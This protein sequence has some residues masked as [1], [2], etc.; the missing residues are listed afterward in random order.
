VAVLKSDH[1][2]QPPKLA[3]AKKETKLTMS[4]KLY[5]GNLSYDTTEIDLQ[6]T[7][8]EAGTVTEV[9]LMQDKF[10]GK[11][12]GFAFVTMS[13]PEEAQKAISLFHG[14]S[15]G[16]RALTVNEARPREDRPPG[17][18]GGGGQ[19]RSY[20]GGG[21]GGGGRGDRGDRGGGYSKRY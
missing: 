10:T 1:R 3:L 13:S 5:V 12:R 2:K 15:V 20:G 19:R 6:D 14:K 11:S 4:N 7:F 9:A 16:G 18:G 8:A 21:G 17:G